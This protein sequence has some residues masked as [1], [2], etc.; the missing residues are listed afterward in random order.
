[1]TI[2]MHVQ[3][4]FDNFIDIMHTNSLQLHAYP[5]KKFICAH[6]KENVFQK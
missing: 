2:I 4:S 1:M 3:G 6:L 5:K